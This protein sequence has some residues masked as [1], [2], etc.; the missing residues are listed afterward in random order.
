MDMNIDTSSLG[1]VTFFI[2]LLVVGYL[3]YDTYWN[4]ELE[5]VKSSIDGHTYLVQSLPDK[6]DAANLL[7]E[8][9]KKLD[10]I[11][12]HF[13]KTEPSDER[14]QRMI[15]NYN[16]NKLSEGIPNTKYTSYS[17]NKGE[18]IV[19]CLRSRDGKNELADINTMS[20]VAL[21]ELAH[22]CTESIGH[23]DEFWDNFKW[24]LEVALNIGIYQDRDYKKAPQPY[25]GITISDNPLHN[26]KTKEEIEKET[27]K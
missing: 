18:K 8:I 25:C 7:A 6:K 17:I 11:V 27:K 22:I 26:H 9:R 23:T 1:T 16:P 14:V 21:H 4:K 2:L 3:V 5:W 10:T 15:K 20:F 12:E 24:I 19:F 13:S